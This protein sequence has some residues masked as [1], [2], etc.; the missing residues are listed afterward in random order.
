M[1]TMTE[2]G[3]CIISF[4]LRQLKLNFSTVTHKV[5]E[6]TSNQGFQPSPVFF[7]VSSLL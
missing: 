6:L 1:G 7:L 4:L 5:A 3:D 2:A